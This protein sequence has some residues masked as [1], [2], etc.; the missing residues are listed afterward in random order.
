MITENKNIQWKKILLVPVVVWVIF[1]LMFWVALSFGGQIVRMIFALLSIYAPFVLSIIS[2]LFV[3]IFVKNRRALHF[4]ITLI[5]SIIIVYLLTSV[6][7]SYQFISS[8]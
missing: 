2:A 5:V 8:Y 3:I 7:F 6:F 4:F 1:M